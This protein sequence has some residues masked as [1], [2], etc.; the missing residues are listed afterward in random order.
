MIASL[1]TKELTSLSLRRLHRQEFGRL[2]GRVVRYNIGGTWDFLSVAAGGDERSDT[3]AMRRCRV[4]WTEFVLFPKA[5]L[6]AERRG[7]RP[8][9]AYARAENRL[10]WWMARERGSLWADPMKDFDGR[11]GKGGVTTE[12]GR[13]EAAERL[14]GLGR[15]GKAIQALVSPGLAGDTDKVERKLMSKFPTRL[16]DRVRNTFLPPAAGAEMDDLFKVLKTFDKG[17]G[18]GR[19]VSGRSFCLKWWGKRWRTR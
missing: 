14:A 6:R 5:V 4:A 8:G 13:A 12:K 19:R 9:Q 10:D 15:A 7:I 18:E 17:A 11:R 2:C 16:S 1:P 3:M